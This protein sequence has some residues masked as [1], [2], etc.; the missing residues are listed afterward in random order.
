MEQTHH[1]FAN[2]QAYDI[3]DHSDYEVPMTKSTA[4]VNIEQQCVADKKARKNLATSATKG[5]CDNV[6]ESN[7]SERLLR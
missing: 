5:K 1:N 7:Q 4:P 2:K 3:P 6:A